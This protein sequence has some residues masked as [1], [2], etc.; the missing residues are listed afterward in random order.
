VRDFWRG[1]VTA[2]ALAPRLSASGDCFNHRGRKAWACVNFVAAHDGFTVNDLVTYN[3]K[4]N[5]DN[6]EENRDGS[7]D[8]APAA[9]YAAGGYA[10]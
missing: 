7:S 10:I 3:D 4:H 6:G 5:E 2:S 8:K 9:L 1:E